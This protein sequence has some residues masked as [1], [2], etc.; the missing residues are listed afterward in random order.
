MPPSKGRKQLNPRENAKCIPLKG[1]TTC[2]A[3]ENATISTNSTLVGYY[4]F[5]QYVDNVKDFD[6]ELNDYI[7]HDYVTS[8]YRN[9]LGCED[10]NLDNTSALYARYTTSV[11][12]NSIVQNSKDP[13]NVSSTDAPPLCADSC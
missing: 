7:K 6:D 12:C 2:P 13:C 9:I 8:K 1:S 11:L 3:F 10:L 4:P 5:L